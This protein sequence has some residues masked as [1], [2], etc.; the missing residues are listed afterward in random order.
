[1]GKRQ[2]AMEG[3][4]GL[5][6]ETGRGRKGESVKLGMGEGVKWLIKL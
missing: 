4:E 5:S 3:V 2:S 6:Y 1:M